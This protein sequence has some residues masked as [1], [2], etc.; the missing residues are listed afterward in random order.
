MALHVVGSSSPQ[1]NSLYRQLS[2]PPSLH[3][4][5]NVRLFC[6]PHPALSSLSPRW[7]KKCRLSVCV[8]QECFLLQLNKHFPCEISCHISTIQDLSTSTVQ[9]EIYSHP[10]AFFESSSLALQAS[11]ATFADTVWKTIQVKQREPGNVQCILVGGAL[12]HRLS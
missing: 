11:K 6:M 1:K 3:L 9:D 5:V 8:V 12:L 2:T 7:A 10:P 4:P